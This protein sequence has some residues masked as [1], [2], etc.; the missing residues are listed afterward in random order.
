[1]ANGITTL[2]SN[3]EVDYIVKDFNSATDAMISF[4]TVNFGPGTDANRL[5]TNFNKSS[6]SRN[7]LEIVAYVA[8]IFFFYF[9]QQATQSYLQT[10]TVR[11][12][13]RDIA[14]QFGFTPATA[15]SSSGNVQ[16][17]LS[18][19][20]TINRGFKLQSTS[21]VPFFLTNPIVAGAAGVYTGTALQGEIKTQTFVARGVQNE[22]FDLIGPNVIVDA[23]NINPADVSPLMQVSGNSY[24]L[25]NSFLRFNGNDSPVV[26][27]SLGEIIGGGGRCF[28]LGERPNGNPY[29]R[30]GDGIFG[31]K[32]LPGEIVSVTYRTGGGT[33]GN[34]EPNSII[35]L[36]SLPFVSNVT[37]SG[38][39][40][41]GAD[42]QS[43][44]QLR[45]L[46]PASLR[47]LERAVSET[48]Y[49][50]LIVTNFSE[51]FAASTEVNTTDPGIDLNIYVVP[52]GNGIAKITDNALLLTNI[53]NFVDR[54]KMVTI[55]FQI[56]DAFGVDTLI[57]LEIFIGD[58]VSKNTIREAIQEA[59]S[60]F[61]SLNTGAPDG[62]GIGF[63]EQILLK[64]IYE[65]VANIDGI[66][67]VEVKRL[68]YRPRIDYRVQ[69]LVTTYNSTEVSVFP[70]VSESE[71]M[72]AAA[73][74][75]QEPEGTVLF[76]NP[77][78]TN[79]TYN[80]QTGEIVYQFPVSLDGVSPGDLFRNGPGLQEQVAIQTV[81]D[82][83]G[84][85]EVTKI[86]TRADEQGVQ[87][88]TLVET[89]ADAF[90]NL[91]GRYFL[92]YDSG[93]SVAVWFNVSLANTQP[94][95]GANR[96]I[97]VNIATNDNANTVATAVATAVAADGQFLASEVG[98]IVTITNQEKLTVFDAVDGAIPTAFTITVDV[99]GSTP[100][101]LNGTFFDIYDSAGP[102][103]VWFDVDGT[104]TPPPA[105]ISGRLL[106]VN[107]VAND[108]AV[109]VAIAMHSVINA[110]SE[111][112]ATIF[113]NE[114]TVTCDAVGI[115]PDTADGTIP[116]QFTFT[117]ITHGADA[118]TIDGTYFYLYDVNG[119]IAYWY[120]V[121]NAGTPEPAHG[122][123]R[124][125]EI[126]TVTSGMTAAQ[127]AD[128][129][130][131]AISAGI[132]ERSNVVCFADVSGNL[133]NKYFYL[134]SANNATEYYVWYNV[135][136]GGTDPAV[137]GKTGIEV[138]I[139]TNDNANTIG[140]ATRAAINSVAG[141]DFTATDLTG[142]VTITNDLGG[143]CTD[144]ADAISPN[145]TGFAFSVTRQGATFAASDA[146]NVITVI[147]NDKAVVENASAGT[148]GFT[149]NV[150]VQGVGDN[151][152][153]IIFS[154]NIANSSLFILPGQPV[155]PIAGIGAGGSIRN[156]D[157]AYQSFK[158]FKKLNASATN[159]SIDTITDSDIDLSVKTGTAALLSARIL[160]DNSQVFVPGEWATG[161]YY[162]VDG[163][164]NIWEILDNESNTLM[165][166]ITAVNDAAV[167]AVSPGN[168]RIVTKLIGSQIVFNGSVFN[169]QYNSH[170]TFVSIGAQFTQIGTIGDAFQIS[171]LQSKIGNIGVAVDL[172]SYNA[173]TGQI[174]LNGSPDLGGISSGN[175]LID[176]SGQT[177]S[178][179]AVDNRPLPQL[180][181]SDSN[182]T[183]QLVLSGSGVGNQYAQGFKVDITDTY[184]IVSFFLKREGNIVGELTARI[185]LDDGSGLPDV[186]QAVAVSRTV[187]VT[188]LS[189][190][191][192]QKAVFTFAAPPTL[193]AGVQYHLVLSSDISYQ[194]AQRDGVVVFANSGPVAWTYNTL[195]GLIQYASAVD[196]SQVA[197]G[198][199]FED[200]D[201]TL[202]KVL[203]VDDANNRLTLDSGLPV[204]EGSNGNVVAKDNVY[205]GVDDTVPTY[206][207]GEL[208]RF[209][210]AVW[211]NS[212]LGP[213]PFPGPIDAPFSV[214]GPK[215][216]RV[217][218]NLT[219]VLG[220]GA[221][222]SRRY[223]DD[224]NE[225][226][227][228]LG[229]SNGLITS[230]V[231]VNAVGRG[232]V[233]GV[234]NTPVDTFVF[235][236]SRFADDIINLRKNEIPQINL[237]DLIIN[238]YG[239]ID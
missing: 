36:D 206:P 86:A 235:R 51:V 234:P 59:L 65:L 178:V 181:Y 93:G 192:F 183:D 64:D 187:N 204:I 134:Y 203:A 199:F 19:S 228:A 57:T 171:Q 124:S 41:G 125:V 9:D 156:G 162:L 239:G 233:S 70:N 106:E 127:V 201:G 30:F 58:T 76:S 1:M 155:N 152:D 147:G 21:G 200:N 238:I 119:P 94:S 229:V 202:F 182:M 3:T 193:T 66:D 108:P 149:V 219:P 115:R 55:Q 20:G 62:A 26:T 225:I 42:E 24:A 208:A 169:V 114:V 154:V 34:I 158:C 132:A 27:D 46:I 170:N 98:A 12:A 39:F 56:L 231:D 175:L 73:G 168:Y 113:N 22:E 184:S 82:G 95:T 212:T 69:G 221:T 179:I 142:T 172:I 143:A 167:T 61:F 227:F 81:G 188:G 112:T 99:T 11:S 37:N 85:S 118:V 53:S 4:A 222:I 32:L 117:T 54:R 217:E 35:A 77:N 92:L 210:G 48:D 122:A 14:A 6:F 25:V 145:G 195:S 96:H 103:R 177:F 160:I 100:R 31:R 104:S 207:N 176:S 140:A 102:V 130:A 141:T 60:G 196:L 68:T 148:T 230:A 126:S 5:W 38:R 90:G 180:F 185:V 79:F 49:S 205:L 218:S 129:T 189:D 87:Q 191:N 50:D 71:W 190:T 186:T 45:Q 110:D 17:T 136:S 157:T 107:I 120:D 139:S 197:P 101:P 88:V 135:A 2:T 78:P 72:L 163:A 133:N 226:S 144:L 161:A 223:Y 28:I 123:P 84:A 29:V 63:A 74:P 220:P 211:S 47:I 138:A 44:E 80:S 83:T 236:T 194:L 198:N 40:S 151:T 23:N 18:A 13:V 214:E 109:D 128:V 105:P 216:V 153:F 173:P 75:V 8:D 131:T 159:L 215:S 111:F 224:N 116:T 43:I 174:R 10:A 166:S 67:R 16:F 146:A 213:S 232:T 121:D 7:W 237:Q 165:T 89:R 33:Q 164:G 150:I 209:D 52:Q 97:E 91:G 137:P 15:A